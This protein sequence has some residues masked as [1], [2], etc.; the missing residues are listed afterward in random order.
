MFRP[1]LGAAIAIA[2][3]G[4]SSA[5]EQLG[6]DDHAADN[7]F[8]SF[9]KGFSSK[10]HVSKGE[11]FLKS[12][13]VEE[14]KTHKSATNVSHSVNASHAIKKVNRHQELSNDSSL[15]AQLDEIAQSFVRAPSKA[16]QK[17]QKSHVEAMKVEMKATHRV[18]NPQ[19]EGCTSMCKW[20][21]MTDRE[22][23]GQCPLFEWQL[24][25]CD[26]TPPS[27][28]V[29][30]AEA[31]PMDCAVDLMR[32]NVLE[33]DVSNYINQLDVCIEGLP[34]KINATCYVGLGLLRSEIRDWKA[35]ARLK[36]EA[37]VLRE[38]IGN[39]TVIAKEALDTKTREQE[40]IDKLTAVLA[41]S[42]QLPGHYLVEEVHTARGYLDVLGPIP[43][44]RKQLKAA[45][46]DGREAFTT[47]SLYRVKEAMVWLHVAVNKGV[48]FKLDEP[49]P[50]AK[51]MLERLGGLKEALIDLKEASFQGNVSFATLSNVPEAVV[52]LRGAIAAATAAGLESKMPIASD[53]LDKL[54]TLE[55]AVVATA[56]ATAIG[57]TIVNTAG[58]KTID[59]LT[60]A[61][62][63]LNVTVSRD[64]ALGLSDNATTL[65]GVATLDQLLYIKHARE[66]LIKS[67]E[68][69]KKEL[70]SKG[71]VLNDDGEEAALDVLGPAIEW[72]EETGLVKGMASAKKLLSQLAR[73]ERAKENMAQSLE[74]G[75]ATIKS[76]SF[77]KQAIE[78][79]TKSIAGSEAANT[80]AGVA[81]AREQIALLEAIKA[82]RTALAKAGIAANRS[83]EARTGYDEAIDGLN[84]SIV[85]GAE[86]G[87]LA[88]TAIARQQMKTLKAFKKADKDLGE[89]LR[90]VPP[91]RNRP[92]PRPLE[93]KEP[94]LI[95]N[96]TGLKVEDLPEVPMRLTTATMILMSTLLL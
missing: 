8:K 33:A 64:V 57:Q 68:Y 55:D 18:C 22:I 16:Q 83:Q 17:Q 74:L 89:A 72:G 14:S 24:K 39:V 51:R 4:A 82:A 12:E 60:D 95:F 52:R 65:G 31:E 11:K 91:L 42:E 30:G 23:N 78:S 50:T 48:R 85:A 2:C 96:R 59:R 58:A 28:R 9:F 92:Q 34:T 73:V 79:L 81:T 25:S 88:E 63:D 32:T 70:Y 66:A 3:L 75:N 7:P 71:S 49:V 56:N 5:R 76:K 41:K 53:L 54:E 27:E 26:Y 90:K 36:D 10:E 84:S 87:L 46:L 80:T 1:C 77:I 62:A 44:V 43:A 6:L 45:M 94:N 61:V 20:L 47:T 37:E 19:E 35:E 29:E 38:E 93:D 40:A 67:K 13:H 86:A 69:A 15:N 21:K